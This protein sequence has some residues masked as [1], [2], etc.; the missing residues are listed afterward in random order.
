ML[1]N[2]PVSGLK[3][4]RSF[5]TALERGENASAQAMIRT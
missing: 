2:I 1:R 4:D 5:V 3:I